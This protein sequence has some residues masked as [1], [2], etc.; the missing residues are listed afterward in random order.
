V[1]EASDGREALELLTTKAV[2]VVLTDINMP[3]M[4]GLQ[5]LY[6]MKRS[7]H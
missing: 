7:P 5:L 2:D 4:S 6:E 3:N 1:F